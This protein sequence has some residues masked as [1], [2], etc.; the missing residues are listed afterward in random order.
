M[1][2]NKIQRRYPDSDWDYKAI[3]S[4][5]NDAGT[6]RD[7]VY[8]TLTTKGKKKEAVEIFTGSNYIVGSKDRSSSRH[9]EMDKL[10][11]KYKDTVNELKKVHKST[12]W[13]TAKYVNEN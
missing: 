7:V 4:I 6:K 10:P 5:I 12:K 3:S 2:I 11:S 8:Y 13:S 9:Y 1:K